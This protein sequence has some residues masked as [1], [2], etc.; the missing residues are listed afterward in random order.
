MR[1]VDHLKTLG[2]AG[3]EARA[4]LESGKVWVHDAPTADAAREVQPEH[5]RL[6]PSSPHVVVGRDPVIIYRDDHLVVVWKPAGLLSVPAA[7]R[8]GD[9]SI[10][11]KIGHLLGQRMFAVHRLDEMTSGLMAIA[12]SE[13]VQHL[14]R[15]MFAEHRIERRYLAIVR[16]NFP[17]RPMT[18]RSLMVRNRGDGLR[19]ATTDAS[20]ESAKL[21][22]THLTLI[23]QLGSQAALVEARLE[24]G[25]THQVRIHLAETGHP[26]LGDNLY[27]GRGVGRVM[28]RYALHAHVLG[29]RHPITGKTLRFEAPLADELEKYARGLRR[30]R[31]ERP[32]S[33]GPR[34]GKSRT[35]SSKK[36]KPADRI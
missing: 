25:R 17:P 20:D 23:E 32:G 27:G 6:L 28:G 9:T 8:H 12:R 34:R 7:G 30:Q 26:I 10:L 4:A 36:R 21:A 31:S 35:G 2:L 19:G 14:M 15:G 18:V 11:G 33:G 5:V 24:T 3:R 16:G 1:L 29:F 22:V 13:H